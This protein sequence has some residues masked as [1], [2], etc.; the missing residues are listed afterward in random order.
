M[1]LQFQ[2]NKD[3]HQWFYLMSSVTKLPIISEPLSLYPDINQEDASNNILRT[4]G[5]M[6]VVQ[7]AAL[8]AQKFPV[9]S[10][11]S[12]TINAYKDYYVFD[13]LEYSKVLYFLFFSGEITGI[14]G[15]NPAGPIYDVI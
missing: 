5:N 7:T 3:M 2:L 15:Y 8:L 10:V 14:C 12:C 13:Y 9:N 6:L 4:F 1:H 11:T